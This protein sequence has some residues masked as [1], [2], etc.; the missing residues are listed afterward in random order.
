[1][2]GSVAET[3]VFGVA[4]W[5]MREGGL[6]PLKAAAAYGLALAAIAFLTGHSLL[7]STIQGGLAALALWLLIWVEH[8]FHA[9][10]T[11]PLWL[12]ASLVLFWFV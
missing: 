11:L 6:E 2:I 9:M 7:Q 12:I 5:H 8:R 1:M 10:A 4:L 3:V